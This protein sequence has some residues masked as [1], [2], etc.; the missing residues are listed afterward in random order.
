MMFA[1]YIAHSW[2]LLPP[3]RGT[4]SSS[5]RSLPGRKNTGRMMT[6][7]MGTCVS[8][9]NSGKVRWVWLTLWK[10]TRCLQRSDS[11]GIRDWG[12]IFSRQTWGAQHTC[13]IYSQWHIT[14]LTFPLYNHSASPHNFTLNW[15]NFTLTSLLSTKSHFP[16]HISHCSRFPRQFCLGFHSLQSHF[17]LS[18]RSLQ[19]HFLYSTTH[20]PITYNGFWQW[21][22]QFSFDYSALV[23]G[24]IIGF[25][26]VVARVSFGWFR[27]LVAWGVDRSWPRSILLLWSV[28]S[29]CQHIRRRRSRGSG[30]MMVCGTKVPVLS[31]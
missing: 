14:S 30:C 26:L 3:L 20:D 12:S 16:Y 24:G 11:L 22:Q 17:C 5:L 31:L 15:C 29:A 10:A 4:G 18:Y 6:L 23:F 19:S 27:W 13:L 1:S 25:K 7:D 28:P 21:G 2:Q 9:H 8:L